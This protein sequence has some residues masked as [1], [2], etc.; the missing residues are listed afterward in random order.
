MTILSVLIALLIERI[1]PQLIEMRRFDWLRGYAQWSADLF[2]VQRLGAWFG[3]ALVLLPLVLLTWLAV[4]LFEN[5]LFG[6]F[7]LAF[8]VAVVFFCIGP[9]DLDQQIDRYLD[10]L[11]LGDDEQ[12][13]QAGADLT[14]GELADDLDAQTSQVAQGIMVEANIRVFA[15]LFWFAVLGPIAAVVYRVLELFLRHGALPSEMPDWREQLKI[16]LGVLD[17][18]P[19]RLSAF[20][21]MVSGSFEDGLAAYRKAPTESIE[22][23][24]QNNTVLAQVGNSCLSLE[25]N[26][27]PLGR[28]MDQV[29]KARG[30]VLR[31]L[32]VWLLLVLLVSIVS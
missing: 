29:R 7:E 11:E 31:A 9:R 25:P 18:I 26:E 16:V 30:L 8:G 20:A 13:K 23:Y 24:E 17:W 12:R 6:L 32:V 14:G 1:A 15:L 3:L 21:Y 22:L 4:G 2:Q 19:S 28:G 27:D 10:V 5:A